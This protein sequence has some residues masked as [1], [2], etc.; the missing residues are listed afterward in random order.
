[1]HMVQLPVYCADND[2]SDNASLVTSMQRERDEKN[3]RT[4]HVADAVL[5]LYS[6]VSKSFKNSNPT[7]FFFCLS[8]TCYTLNSLC[9]LYV[10]LFPW[11]PFIYL[12]P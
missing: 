2:Q 12:L 7:K 5:T 4:L 8:L 3:K 10:A 9:H 1:M 6:L 11:F